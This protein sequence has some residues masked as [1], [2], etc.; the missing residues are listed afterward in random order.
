MSRILYFN[1]EAHKY[2]DDLNNE[3]LSTTTLLGQYEPKF[4]SKGQA[5]RLSR[6]GIGKY[7]GKSAKQIEAMWKATTESACDKGNMIHDELENGVKEVSKFANAVKSLRNYDPDDMSRLFTLDDI[8][9]MDYLKPVDPNDFYEKVGYKYPIIQKTIEWYCAQ[10]YHLFA[11][12][13]IYDEKRLISG[14][15]DLLALNLTTKVFVII[16]WKTNKDDITFES[17]YYK[18]D[19]E[20]QTTNEKVVK[21]N[22]MLHYPL[23]NLANC[24]GSKYGLQLSVYAK[25]VEQRGFTW[26]GSIIFHIRDHYVLNEY[27]QPYRDEN[28]NYVVDED[29]GR[30]V[31]NI[32]MPYY[33]DEVDRVFA[34]HV[35]NNLGS[36]VQY[37]MGL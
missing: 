2:T 11:E 15:I 22:D 18:R 37:K 35:K 4:D 3:Y 24:K 10:G 16:D 7:K 17:Y 36:G 31:N 28:N 27:R 32:V 5:A 25:M 33:T 14:M 23:D 21:K 12:A 1:E 20:G 34:H 26:G 6:L 8:L 19:N 13:G 29:K 30:Y 9:E